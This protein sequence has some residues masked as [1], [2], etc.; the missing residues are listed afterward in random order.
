MQSLVRHSKQTVDFGLI[1]SK[2]RS[3]SSERKHI[4]DGSKVIRYKFCSKLSL[5]V[6]KFQNEFMKASFLPK[7][8]QKIVVRRAEIL[9]IFR[10]YFGRND[11]F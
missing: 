1:L 8:E 3:L 9:T 2:N 7:Y 5:K 4:N 11:D 6:S 10:S